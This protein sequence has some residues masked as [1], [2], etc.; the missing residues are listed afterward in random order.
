M[1]LPISE[2]RAKGSAPFGIDA[3]R[4]RRKSEARRPGLVVDKKSRKGCDQGTHVHSPYCQA[5]MPQKNLE[6]QRKSKIKEG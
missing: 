5:L 2:T 6:T 1:S 4:H 3:L